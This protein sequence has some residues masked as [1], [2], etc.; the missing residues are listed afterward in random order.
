[1]NWESVTGAVLV[2]GGLAGYVLGTVRPFSGRAFTITAIMLG[3]LLVAVGRGR[4]P[5]VVA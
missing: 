1:M 4:E 3:L 5:G 2:A